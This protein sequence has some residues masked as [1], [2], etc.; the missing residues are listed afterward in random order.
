MLFSRGEKDFLIWCRSLIKSASYV[1]YIRVPAFFVRA[2]GRSDVPGSCPEVLQPHPRLHVKMAWPVRRPCAS[3]DATPRE[4]CPSAGGE[5][6][7]LLFVHEKRETNRG[8]LWSPDKVAAPCTSL[9]GPLYNFG[10]SVSSDH[11]W[12]WWWSIGTSEVVSSANVS[13]V[14]ANEAKTADRGGNRSWG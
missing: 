7:P 13:D 5:K 6:M 9:A 14:N 11:P 10:A 2:T 12:L 8:T 4:R 3:E 1:P